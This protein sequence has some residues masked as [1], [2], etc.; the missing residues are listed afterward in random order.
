MHYNEEF[1]PMGAHM[2]C[3]NVAYTSVFAGSLVSRHSCSLIP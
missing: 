2:A 3:E 1:E